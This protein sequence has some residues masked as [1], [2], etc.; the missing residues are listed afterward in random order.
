MKRTILVLAAIGAVGISS[1]A[2]AAYVVHTQD[3]ANGA[4]THA[5]LSDNS[6]WHANIGSGSVQANNLD[7][8]TKD[9]LALWFVAYHTGAIL[10]QSGGIK[11]VTGYEYTLP[12]STSLQ[13]CAL[14]ATGQTPE[15]IGVAP[16]PS[17]SYQLDVTP[18]D[19]TANF[20]VAVYCPARA[21][22]EAAYA[23]GPS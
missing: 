20:S 6:A 9:H 7:W 14:T 16:D 8:Q 12:V 15:E 10:Q 1:G 21:A 3:I 11:Q 4:V 13:N 19:P 22:G 17:V 2:T 5:K 23:S 18:T